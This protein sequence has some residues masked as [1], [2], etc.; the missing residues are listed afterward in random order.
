[1]NTTYNISREQLNNFVSNHPHGHLLQ[2]YEW[3]EAQENFGEPIFRVAVKDGEQILGVATVIIKTFYKN[4][5]YIYCPRGP[6]F[7]ETASREVHEMLLAAISEEAKKRGSL[8]LRVAPETTEKPSWLDGFKKADHELEPHESLILDLAKQE[9]Q[10]LAEMKPKTRYNIKLAQKKGVTV[11]SGTDETFLNIFLRL[12]K[13]TASRDNFTAHKDAYYQS[14]LKA[15][16]PRGLL[17]VYV[18][19]AEGMPIAANL[20]SSFGKRVTYM[21]GA[22]SNE[23]RNLMPTFALQWEAIRDA[24]I[25]G[26]TEY[27]FWGIT[28][29][30]DEKHPW[31]GI[32]RFKNGFGGSVVKY[33]GAY[34]LVYRKVLTTLYS[35]Y[36]KFR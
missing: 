13:E 11:T 9:E 29:S 12:N 22:S 17:K 24:K 6:L 8:F 16:A 30:Q 2:S 5:H 27:D 19:Y 20:V 1:M 25:Q 7:V 26:K 33:I 31:A 34:D 21:H 32:T 36:R 23:G 14:I 18:A 35:L 10:L 3:G 15:L 4:F 28:T